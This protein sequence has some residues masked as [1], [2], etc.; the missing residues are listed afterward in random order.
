MCIFAYY[1]MLGGGGRGGVGGRPLFLDP[2]LG[3]VGL[4][5]PSLDFSSTLPSLS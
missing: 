2:A 3:F 5:Q 4:S 1:L